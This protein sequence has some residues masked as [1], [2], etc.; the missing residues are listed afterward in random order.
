MPVQSRGSLAVDYLG[1]LLG[2]AQRDRLR[3]TRRKKGNP[4]GGIKLVAKCR[5]ALV[6]YEPR[7]LQPKPFFWPQQ[8]VCWSVTGFALSLH[9]D[10]RAE[11]VFGNRD[12]DEIVGQVTGQQRGTADH[13]RWLYAYRNRVTRP[14]ICG[15]WP[16]AAAAGNSKSYD[17][18]TKNIC[19]MMKAIITGAAYKKPAGR[20]FPPT[21]LFVPKGRWWND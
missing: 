16:L 21:R 2:V 20:W 8:H 19:G 13:H 18:Q 9:V 17:L 12:L 7:F 4:A 3:E 14:F 1:R 6:A 11:E 15:Q 5:M 10:G